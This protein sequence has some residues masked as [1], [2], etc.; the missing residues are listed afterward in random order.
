M[1]GV[2]E[3]FFYSQSATIRVCLRSFVIFDGVAA[4][5]SDRGSELINVFLGDSLPLNSCSLKR[6]RRDWDGIHPDFW[7]VNCP[8]SVGHPPRHS[9]H[10]VDGFFVSPILRLQSPN[11]SGAEHAI[12]IPNE[13]L[14]LRCCF[15]FQAKLHTD[16]WGSFCSSVLW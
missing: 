3:A 2:P 9:N 14:T 1:W 8:C 12:C 16:I 6:Q 11:F 15:A 4:L 7:S 5:A 10:I 13:A